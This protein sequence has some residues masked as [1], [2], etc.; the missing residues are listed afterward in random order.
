[1]NAYNSFHFNLDDEF[2]PAITDEQEGGHRVLSFGLWNGL[3]IFLS[4]EQAIILAETILGTIE[5]C[6]DEE[7]DER[8]YDDRDMDDNNF[9]YKE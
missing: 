1:M 2:T 4:T 6:G 7:I 9:F 3:R 5:S 8:S